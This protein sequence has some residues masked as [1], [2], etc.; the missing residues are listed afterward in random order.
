ML[1]ESQKDRA[2]ELIS[3]LNELINRLAANLPVGTPFSPPASYILEVR[4]GFMDLLNNVRPALD[5]QFLDFENPAAESLGLTVAERGLVTTANSAYRILSQSLTPPDGLTLSS[6]TTELALALA[7]LQ[8]LDDVLWDESLSYEERVH[9][10]QVVL[11]EAHLAARFELKEEH[12]LQI[13]LENGLAFER[14]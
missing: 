3:Q 8:N 12:I 7:T 11:A 14:E 1:T 10:A 6:A 2:L 5:P 4:D 9:T 13:D